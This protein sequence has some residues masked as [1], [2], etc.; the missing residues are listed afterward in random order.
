[1]SVVKPYFHLKRNHLAVKL[2]VVYFILKREKLVIK[3]FPIVRLTVLD[4]I[5]SV[6]APIVLI[7]Q[8]FEY[9]VLSYF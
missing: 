7:V 1:M 6:V 3:I 9:Y 4:I 8:I 2:S 5:F